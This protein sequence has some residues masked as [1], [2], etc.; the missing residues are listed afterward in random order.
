MP[1]GRNI[2]HTEVFLAKKL[3]V[4]VVIYPPHNA[5]EKVKYNYSF[6]SIVPMVL[7]VAMAITILIFKWFL[8]CLM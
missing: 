7:V 8:L 4:V 1:T 3:G 5:K 2:R 6:H